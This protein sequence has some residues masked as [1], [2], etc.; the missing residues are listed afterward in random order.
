[1]NFEMRGFDELKANAP[2]LK[3]TGLMNP[4]SNEIE[5]CSVP[6]ICGYKIVV[7]ANAGGGI[8]IRCDDAAGNHVPGTEPHL[9]ISKKAFDDYDHYK[10]NTPAVNDVLECLRKYLTRIHAVINKKH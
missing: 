1:M 6:A 9:S 7:T 10:V 2:R 4:I 3:A 5:R 8:E